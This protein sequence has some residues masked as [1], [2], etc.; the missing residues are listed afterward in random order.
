[1]TLDQARQIVDEHE[2]R[3]QV[4]QK[5]KVEYE[6][7]R[8][9]SKKYKLKLITAVVDRIGKL[10]KPI[11]DIL[12]ILFRELAPYIALIMIILLIIW[13]FSSSGSKSSSSQK[14]GQSSTSSSWWPKWLQPNYKL[15]QLFN[16]NSKVNSIGRP[17]EK[18]GRCDNIEFQDM[19]GLCPRT[20]APEDTKWAISVSKIPELEKLP[21]DLYKK[22]TKDGDKLLVYIPWEA[23]GT[24][25]VPKCSKAY[26]KVKDDNG[27]EQKESASYLFKDNGL[28]CERVT[29][30]STS[31]GAKY[32]PI[33]STNKIDY[34][35]ESNPKCSSS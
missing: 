30:T 16:F 7:R 27:Q 21:D 20:Y 10:L 8:I 1:M 33:N 12:E 2:K 28:T 24:F 6:G 26:F 25:Y 13:A 23:E 29:K 32:R 22:Y 19:D 5:L 15:K 11:L 35:S 31:Y 14:R 3:L 34:A 4:D 9:E 18:T 17:I